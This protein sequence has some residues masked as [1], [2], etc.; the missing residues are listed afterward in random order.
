MT[1]L[2]K[3]ND[4][5]TNYTKKKEFS[6]ICLLLTGELIKAQSKCAENKS[7]LNHKLKPLLFFHVQINLR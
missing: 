6:I 4:V 7:V 5:N 3:L 1:N 2:F